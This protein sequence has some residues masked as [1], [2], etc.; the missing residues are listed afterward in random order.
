[1]S[2][3]VLLGIFCCLKHNFIA[4]KMDATNFISLFLL[5]FALLLIFNTAIF[6]QE[7]EYKLCMLH[8]F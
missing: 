6:I 1:M 4:H 2:S 8:P 5:K 3:L 7:T